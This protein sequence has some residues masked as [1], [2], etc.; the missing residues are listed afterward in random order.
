MA[1]FR[2][3]KPLLLCSSLLF[4][5]F[6]CS[7]DDD[8]DNDP[9]VPVVTDSTPLR[10]ITSSANGEIISYSYDKDGR[11]TKA[12]DY[13]NDMT[14]E[15][16]YNPV[17]V[18]MTTY[19]ESMVIKNLKFNSDGFLTYAEWGDK[20]SKGVTKFEYSSG[21]LTSIQNIESDG[22][23]DTQVLTWEYGNLLRWDEGVDPYD[24]DRQVITY[25]YGN[26]ENKNHQ[27]SYYHVFGFTG[28][29]EIGWLGKGPA[30]FMEGMTVSSF[31][32]EGMSADN[33][34]FDYTLTSD[35]YID[36]EKITM[37]GLSETFKYNY[38]GSRAGNV[39]RCKPAIGKPG[40]MRLFGTKRK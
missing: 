22:Y 37:D 3:F 13:F 2:L 18:K 19:D 21:H 24:P 23:E 20:E 33:F 11:M 32:T 38:L 15:F 39:G 9:D 40:T 34:S 5:G 36:T 30:N 6:S 1:Y 28:F 4:M 25:K 10:S 17:E 12:V 8:D 35:G 16:S 7:D 26:L 14:V 29:N 27:W 31:T